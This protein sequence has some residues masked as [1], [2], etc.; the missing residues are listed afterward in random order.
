MK[1]EAKK[2]RSYT[3]FN[4][5]RK[6]ERFRFRG[7]IIP[8]ETEEPKNGL[9]RWYKDGLTG[10]HKGVEIYYQAQ[11]GLGSIDK[12]RL[13]GKFK[14]WCLQYGL[15][16]RL[17]WPLTIHKEAATKVNVLRCSAQYIFENC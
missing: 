12:A 13:R 5:K 1:F 8:T 17:L 3:T 10:R 4:R 2:S 9:G 14:V 15:S 11:K 16:P 7:E 6:E